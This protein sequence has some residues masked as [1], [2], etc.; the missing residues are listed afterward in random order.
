MPEEME[1]RKAVGALQ[2]RGVKVGSVEHSS[3]HNDFAIRVLDF[4]FTG[5]QL[6]SVMNRGELNEEGIRRF[7]AFWKLEEKMR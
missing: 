5:T 4:T 3:G 6:I 7:A 1:V 2:S